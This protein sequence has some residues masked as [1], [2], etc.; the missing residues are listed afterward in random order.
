M[1]EEALYGNKLSAFWRTGWPQPPWSDQP[2]IVLTNQNEG[3]KFAAFRR[4]LVTRLRNV[5]F[6]ERPLQG[7]HASGHGAFRRAR[8]E[9]AV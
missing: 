2:F 9:T 8:P 3:P 6:L 5:G 1:A 4:E 7:H